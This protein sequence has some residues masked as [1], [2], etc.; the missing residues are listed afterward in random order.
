MAAT[1]LGPGPALHEPPLPAGSAVLSLP[2]RRVP[3]LGDKK[4]TRDGVRGRAWPDC[5]DKPW[6][7]P[8][9]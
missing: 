4:G 3:D 8:Q 7:P 5:P 6:L 2:A 9:L 1:A